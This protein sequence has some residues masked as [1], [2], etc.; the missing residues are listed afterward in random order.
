MGRGEAV[1]RETKWSL[2]VNITME[3][4]QRLVGKDA[5]PSPTLVGWEGG[6]PPPGLHRALH[7]PLGAAKSSSGPHQPTLL[8]G[9]EHAIYREAALCPDVRDP[10]WGAVATGGD[11][12]GSRGRKVPHVEGVAAF[13]LALQG[14]GEQAPG[15]GRGRPQQWLSVRGVALGRRPRPPP[16]WSPGVQ[17]LLLSLTFEVQGGE[18]PHEAVKVGLGAGGRG[19][20]PPGAPSQP[21]P[22]AQGTGGRGVAASGQAGT[23][24]HELVAHHHLGRSGH[25]GPAGHAAQS[26][27]LGPVGLGVHVGDGRRG[28]PRALLVAD[29]VAHHEDDDEDQQRGHDDAAD[30]QDHG[31]A[32]DLAVHGL[33]LRVVGLGEELGAAH[34]VG[35]RERG[36]RVVPHGQHAQVVASPGHKVVDHKGLVGGW[37]HPGRWRG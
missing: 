24:V 27:R 1:D 13:G 3:T 34:D 7:H 11:P 22:D 21:L 28:L 20:E 4:P 8:E 23:E 35:S 16:A 32:Q 37:D 36:G 2:D 14:Q 31:A 17:Q 18:G 15:P 9:Q 10:P 30:D 26:G 25:G 12:S 19:W 5:S 29:L 6:G 33:A